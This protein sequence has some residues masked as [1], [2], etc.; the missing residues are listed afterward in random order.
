VPFFIAFDNKTIYYVELTYINNNMSKYQNWYDQ[1]T[2][3]GQNRETKT[4]H[5]KHHIVPKSLGGS[6]QKSNLT[7]LTPREHFICHWLLVKIYAEGEPHWKML[8]ALRIMRAENKNQTRYKTKITSRVYEKLKVE[9]ATLQSERHTGT[10]NP[11]YGKNHSEEVKKKISLANKGR[12]Q[13]LEEKMKQKQAMTGKKR[14]EFS[15][16]WRENLSKNHKSTQPDFDGSLSEET[17]KKIGDRIR[18]RKQTEEEKLARSLAN[19]GKKKP[20]KLCPHCGQHVAVNVF[21]RWHG[22]KCKQQA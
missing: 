7:Y 22:D 8:N 3:R 19:M 4:G 15:Q 20:T 2:Q 6:N 18:G 16:D 5:E 12:K 13:P 14:P 11:F 9:Y 21:P 1:I 17:R 10:N